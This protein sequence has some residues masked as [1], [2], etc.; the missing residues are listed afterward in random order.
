MGIRDNGEEEK[1]GKREERRSEES[2]NFRHCFSVTQK[3]DSLKLVYFWPAAS[4]VALV[5]PAAVSRKASERATGGPLCGP[6]GE[7]ARERASSDAA[8]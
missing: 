5:A 8:H 6:L 4:W 7:L 1:K 2:K 3:S